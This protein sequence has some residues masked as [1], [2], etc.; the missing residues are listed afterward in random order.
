MFM[1]TYTFWHAFDKVL[2]EKH[3]NRIRV[4]QVINACSQ[5]PLS[6]SRW[7]LS[8]LIL[9]YLNVANANSITLENPL[10]TSY[11]QTWVMQ[12]GSKFRVNGC[13]LKVLSFNS[14][15]VE[16]YLPVMI[17]NCQR[18]YS[19]MQSVETDVNFPSS[20]EEVRGLTYCWLICALG[21]K[22]VFLVNCFWLFKHV[23]YRMKNAFRLSSW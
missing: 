9:L 19:H 22:A 15:A 11:G 20:L 23:I 5:F 18:Q 13:N 3:A 8:I 4:S 6:T 10:C 14:K 12:F 17:L 21:H 1:H 7:W 2:A 16:L